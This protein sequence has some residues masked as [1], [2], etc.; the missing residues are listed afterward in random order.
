MIATVPV[1]VLAYLAGIVTG[2]ISLLVVG[3]VV[4]GLVHRAA[5]KPQGDG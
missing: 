2:W 5:G 3:G 1:D 4:V